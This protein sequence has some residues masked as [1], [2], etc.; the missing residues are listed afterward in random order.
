MS[1]FDVCGQMMFL[2][3]GQFPATIETYVD[4]NQLI[5]YRFNGRCYHRY[6]LT[7]KRSPIDISGFKVRVTTLD[8]KRYAGFVANYRNCT[9]DG[10]LQINRY[11]FANQSQEPAQIFI[12]LADIAQVEAIL[13]S[14]PRWDGSDNNDFSFRWRR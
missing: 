8:T 10:F 3:R 9:H 1:L 13:Q 4:Y 12:P 14:R 2:Q 11:D 6:P 7:F 5:L